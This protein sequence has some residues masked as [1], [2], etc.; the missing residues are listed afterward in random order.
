LLFPEGTRTRANERIAFK[1][2]A[3]TIAARSRARVQPIAIRCQPLFQTRE[4]PWHYAPRTKPHYT[5]RILPAI[6]MSDIVPADDVERHVRQDL[7][8][9]ILGIIS[10]ELDQ[11]AVTESVER[12]LHKV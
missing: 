9:A 5:I 6:A 11:L 2:G 7:N 1:L 3:A 4:T 10:R 12:K 8:A